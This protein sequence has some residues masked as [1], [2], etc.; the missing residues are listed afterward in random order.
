MNDT[1]NSAILED[2]YSHSDDTG[3]PL[4]KCHFFASKYIVVLDESIIE[5]L[6]LSGDDNYFYQQ[7]TKEGVLLLRLFKI[8]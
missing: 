7:V 4:K 6:N 1:N 8:K 2:N 5:Q 3:Y